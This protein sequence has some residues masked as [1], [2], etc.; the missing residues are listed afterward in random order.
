MAAEHAP[1]AGCRR[2]HA[3]D[4]LVLQDEGGNTAAL[5]DEPAPPASGP[6]QKSQR[7]AGESDAASVSGSPS[8][9]T[10]SKPAAT[11]AF[12]HGQ[13]LDLAGLPC[14]VKLYDFREGQVKLNET[15]EFV[16]VLGY[17]QPAPAQEEELMKGGAALASS[18][19]PFHGLTD[20]SRKIPPP[21]LAPRVHC[22]CELS[23]AGCVG[24]AF[25][26]VF[27]FVFFFLRGPMCVCV[28][29]FSRGGGVVVCLADAGLRGLVTS[30]ENQPT[31]HS[32]G[33][34]RCYAG[35]F[36][37]IYSNGSRN[38]VG[39]IDFYCNTYRRCVCRPCFWERMRSPASS[40]F[41]RSTAD[42]PILWNHI[43]HMYACISTFHGLRTARPR[44]KR[45][46]PLLLPTP[47]RVLRSPPRV[48]SLPSLT[49]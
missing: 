48:A 7:A 29:F 13:E 47:S 11:G 16:G 30:C 44:R 40:G 24:F 18:D 6:P 4:L 22:V 45:Y 21:S 34:L 5:G 36:Y 32:C 3:F 27:C 12:H 33:W 9:G 28:F 17:D 46:P 15:A 26:C 49:S 14:V 1:S 20:F 41:A 38:S 35:F 42:R 23:F 25:V 37:P 43:Q 8:G 39:W 19:N 10:K 2:A 31:S